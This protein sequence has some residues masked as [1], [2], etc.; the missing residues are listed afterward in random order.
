VGKYNHVCFWV[1]A[2]HNFYMLFYTRMNRYNINRFT[3]DADDT[4]GTDFFN[5]LQVEVNES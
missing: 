5:W 1:D 2:S 3:D 4:D